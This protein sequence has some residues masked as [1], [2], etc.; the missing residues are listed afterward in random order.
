VVKQ[1][2]EIDVENFGLISVTAVAL[3]AEESQN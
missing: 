3:M 2:V 1:V